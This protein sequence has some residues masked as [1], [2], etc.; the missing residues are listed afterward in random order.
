MLLLRVESSEIITPFPVLHLWSAPDVLLHV[1]SFSVP[2]PARYYVSNLPAKVSL[3]P[4]D[5]YSCNSQP[6]MVFSF[7][8][9]CLKSVLQL[10]QVFSSHE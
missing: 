10:F 8:N 5:P 9:L 1:Q 3:L 2:A 6:P 7:F 4:S